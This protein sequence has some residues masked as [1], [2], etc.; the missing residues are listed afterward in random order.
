ML[1][2]TDLKKG[3]AFIWNGKPYEVLEASFSRMQQRKAVVQAKIKDLATGKILETSFQPSNQFQE[4]DI[5]KRTLTFLYTHRGEYIFSNPANPRERFT[6]TEDEVAH[7]RQ[8]LKKETPVTALF[9]GEK[10]LTLS[11]PIKMDLKVTETPPGVQGDRA[12][13]GTKAATLE[14]GAVIQVPLFINEGDIIRANTETGEYAE[15]MEKA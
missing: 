4:A 15:R 1:T 13:G 9:F 14:T 6:L 8:W 5:E 11:V 12:Q 10:L 3:T 7:S 2:Y